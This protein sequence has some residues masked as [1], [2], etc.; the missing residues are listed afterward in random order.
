MSTMRI[1]IPDAIFPGEATIEQALLTG[2][3]D[4]EPG[5]VR[6]VANLTKHSFRQP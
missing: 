3:P 1:L 6:A 4:D 5:E 2:G